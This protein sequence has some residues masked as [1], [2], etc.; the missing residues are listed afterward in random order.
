MNAGVTQ[1]RIHKVLMGVLL[2]LARILLR[3]GV[4]YAEFSDL[5]KNAF[6]EVAS[7]DYG[8][9]NRPTN[10]ARVAVMTGLSRKEVSRVRAALAKSRSR[11][12]SYRS[13]PAEILHRWHTD[14]VF[15]DSA[16]HPRPLSFA[17]ARSFT[18]L[19]Q[20]VTGDI[21]ARTA[22]RE[23]SRSGMLKMAQGKKLMPVG[24]EFVPDS[25]SEKAIEGLQYG[26]RRLA[27]TISFNADPQNTKAPRIERIVHTAGVAASDIKLVRDGLIA[28]VAGFSHQIDD[29]LTLF[30]R[31]PNRPKKSSLTYFH[32][33]VGLY[34]FENPEID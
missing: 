15:C 3:C 30:Q 22:E 12:L 19:V 31:K 6:V 4:G 27:E 28:I 10:I 5:A 2:P 17:G 32:L 34:Y 7:T 23:L 29:Y 14:P 1:E 33:G 18:T 9:R 11:T 16:G 21:P 25:A 24:R 26:L 8:V 13:V 20:A